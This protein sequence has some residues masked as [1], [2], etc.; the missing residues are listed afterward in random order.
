MAWRGP[1]VDQGDG[2]RHQ[3]RVAHLAAR[4]AR[5]LRPHRSPPVRRARTGI[6]FDLCH[7]NPLLADD[8]AVADV[9]FAEDGSLWFLRRA[10][11]PEARSQYMGSMG[12]ARVVRS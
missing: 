3:V 7:G 12:G 2:R 8:A 1:H 9:F 4:A 11:R 10:D 6:A 5:G